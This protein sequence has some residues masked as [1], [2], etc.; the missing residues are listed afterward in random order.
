MAKMH[1]IHALEDTSPEVRRAALD[2]L[3]RRAYDSNT[4]TALRQMYQK[5]KRVGL[6]K[7][8]LEHF[9]SLRDKSPT[10]GALL[11]RAAKEETDPYLRKFV[12]GLISKR[13]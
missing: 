10:A 12:R 9:W 3:E 4:E 2:G 11:E 6:R 5:E 8:I 13:G 7:K 1:L